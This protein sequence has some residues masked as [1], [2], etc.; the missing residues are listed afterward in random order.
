MAFSEHGYAG[1]VVNHDVVVSPKQQARVR[2]GIG[3]KDGGPEGIGPGLDAADGRVLPGKV[4]DQ[5][6]VGRHC[7]RRHAGPVEVA[8]AAFVGHGSP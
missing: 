5:V 7:G 3:G 6:H 8:L 1:L 2:V 4:A